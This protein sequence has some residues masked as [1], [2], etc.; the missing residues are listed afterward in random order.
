MAEEERRRSFRAVDAHACVGSEVACR[1]ARKGSGRGACRADR[2]D[3]QRYSEGRGKSAQRSAVADPRCGKRACRRADGAALR[4]AARRKSEGRIRARDA[5]QLPDGT[6]ARLV[7]LGALAAEVR[8]QQPEPAPCC[9]R[10]RSPLYL[11]GPDPRQA[12][13]AAL[14]QRSAEALASRLSRP[15]QGS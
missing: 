14:S 1:P 4:Q 8:R 2:L 13:P 9:G 11:F 7:W 12:L 5:H 6:D 15:R 3:R 10:R